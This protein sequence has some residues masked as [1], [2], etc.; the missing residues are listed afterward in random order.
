MHSP[1]YP[2]LREIAPKFP[3]TALPQNA[4]LSD[5]I[6]VHWREYLMEGAELGALMLG[7]C[8]SGSYIYWKAS[9]L[10]TFPK[11]VD[12][13]VMGTLV[14]IVTLA[15]IWSPF[16]R[17]TG[18]HFNPALTFTYYCLGFI[19]RWDTMFYILSQFLG[20]LGGVL[21]AKLIL[22]RR[23]SMPPVSYVITL[24]GMNGVGSAFLVIFLF[25]G[26]VMGTIL[27][28]SNRPRL[29]GSTPFWVAGLTIIFYTVSPNLSGFSVNPA[30]SFSSA[31][32]A[33][34]WAGLWIYFLAPCC[35][36]LTAAALYT[37][38]PGDRRIYCAK[39]L[40]D[41]IS[42]CP[43]YCQFIE[44]LPDMERQRH[45]SMNSR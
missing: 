39:V 24:P 3:V 38:W 37:H 22:R 2:A 25:A 23:L 45:T 6:R 30:R 31:L 40:H 12:A 11:T 21:V 1:G 26:I 44:M 33:F 16:G 9:P 42:P 28:A 14:A 34:L 36:M 5:A 32:F 15:I 17:R 18:A 4:T 43:F 41:R 13:F 20:G 27:F 35:G 10:S 8:F 7:I 29:V 19:H